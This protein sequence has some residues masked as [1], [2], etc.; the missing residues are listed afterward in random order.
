LSRP[1]GRILVIRR[2][3]VGDAVLTEPFVRNLRL[4]YP[5]ARIDVVMDEGYEQVLSSCPDIDE[6]LV[7]PRGRAG[8]LAKRAGAWSSLART[9]VS[10]H[11]DLAFDLARNDRALLPLLLSRA[12]QRVSW[13]SSDREWPQRRHYTDLLTTTREKIESAHIVDLNNEVLR[14]VGVPTPERIPR[15]EVPEDLRE[16]ARALLRSRC[17]GV[18]D[19]PFTLVHPG[20]GAVPKLWPAEH[21]AAVADRNQRE[22][23]RPVC[24]VAGPGEGQLVQAIVDRMQTEVCALGEVADFPLLYGILAESEYLVSNDTGPSHMAA[25]V[26]TPVCVVFGAQPAAMWRPLGAGHEFVTPP[27]PCGGDCV[28]PDACDVGDPI[29]MYCVRRVSVAAVNEAVDRIESRITRE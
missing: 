3:Y 8:S 15:L 21:F 24:V 6:I 1:I 22:F 7:L 20:G 12:A 23:G 25:A 19:G 9:L 26:G 29:K 13:E 10:R 16:R 5:N 11:Y 27:L 28:M 17:A 4:A 2:R 14:L 18:A